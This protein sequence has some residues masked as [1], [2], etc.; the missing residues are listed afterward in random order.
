MRA[1]VLSSYPKA[2]IPAMNSDIAVGFEALRG[3]I[4]SG[5]RVTKFINEIVPVLLIPAKI[6]GI[7]LDT[8]ASIKEEK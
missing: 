4:I 1:A 6:G 8:I 5:T 3:G 7:E 2:I